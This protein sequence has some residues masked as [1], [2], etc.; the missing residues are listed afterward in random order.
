MDG[1][2]EGFLSLVQ[3]RRSVRRFR[4]DMVPIELINRMVEIATWAPSAGN[5]QDWFFSIVTS[6]DVKRRMA[7]AVRRRWDAIIAANRG[8]GFVEEVESYVAHFSS[9]AD[10]AAVIIVSARCVDS[11]QRHLL[12]DDAAA[13]VGGA[14]SAAMAA[15]NLM[16]AA[17]ALGLG[18]C[19]MTGALA[20]RAELGEILELAKKYE[21]ICLIAV[22]WPDECPA[23]PARKPLTEIARFW[24]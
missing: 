14:C 21:I 17:H 4:P 12:S 1:S 13:T 2:T 22:G 16:L 3:S 5:R 6:Q 9:F 8:S 15:Q 20:A 18:S 24:P 19:C 7:E 23:P 11:V 10:A